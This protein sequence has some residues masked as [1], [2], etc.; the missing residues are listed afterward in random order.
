MAN[1]QTVVPG[2]LSYQNL[3]KR[4][5]T[6]IINDHIRTKMTD[7]VLLYMKNNKSSRIATFVDTWEKMKLGKIPLN[8][9]VLVEMIDE[10]IFEMNFRT[11]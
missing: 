10:L 2:S 6:Q 8:P 11:N 3:S 9:T 5:R 4:Q 1:H 7:R